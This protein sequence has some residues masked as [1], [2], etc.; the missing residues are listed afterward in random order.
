MTAKF[1]LR[2]DT[3][4]I[5][6]YNQARPFASFLPGI[7]GEYGKPMWVFYTNRGQC[8]SSFGVR[9]KACSMMEFYPANKAY[10]A[11]PLLGFR[12]FIRFKKGKQWE[13][14]EPFSLHPAQDCRQILRIRPHEIEIEETNRALGI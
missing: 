8:I 14:Y 2:D 7:A 6:Q 5:E 13:L 3:F 10:T 12:T 1:T 11:T 9:N 4:V